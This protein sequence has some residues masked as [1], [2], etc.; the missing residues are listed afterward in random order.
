MFMTIISFEPGGAVSFSPG[1]AGVLVANNC[2][3]GG[4]VGVALVGGGC[5]GWKVEAPMCL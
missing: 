4:A 2:R 1:E 3:V 5:G